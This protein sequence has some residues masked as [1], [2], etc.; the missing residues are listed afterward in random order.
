L[1]TLAPPLAVNGRATWA[2]LSLLHSE[3]V[4]G[5]DT[6]NADGHGFPG[7]LELALGPNALL[8]IGYGRVIFNDRHSAM[9][10]N[11]SRA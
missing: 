3:E 1:V 11:R 7:P 5:R 10:R 6:Q 4:W 2:I 8:L 9:P